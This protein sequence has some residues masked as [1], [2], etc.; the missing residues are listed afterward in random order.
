MSDSSNGTNNGYHFV[1]VYGSL[2]RGFH[3][4]FILRHSEFLGEFRS[5]DP[6]WRMISFNVYPGV[7]F[8]YLNGSHVSGELF[9]VDDDDLVRLDRLESN[10]SFYTRS[11]IELEGLENQPVWMYILNDE[12]S[13]N[14]NVRG[15]SLNKETNTFSWEGRK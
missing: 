5:K 1:F 7:L 14:D 3:N 15:V 10:G 12:Y 2:K 4:N 13:D 9:L 6:D 8:S 11:E